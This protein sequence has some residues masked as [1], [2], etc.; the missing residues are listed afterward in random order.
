MEEGAGRIKDPANWKLVSR[1]GKQRM[2]KR[3]V[4]MKQ[5]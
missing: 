5:G 4:K 1:N 2:K 3:F